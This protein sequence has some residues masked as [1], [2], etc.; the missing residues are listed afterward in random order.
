M[1]Y[2]LFKGDKTQE[3]LQGQ[4]TCDVTQVSSHHPILG[5]HCNLKGRVLFNFRLFLVN[6]VYCMQLPASMLDLAVTRLQKFAIFSKTE[7]LIDSAINLPLSINDD[8]LAGIPW[9]FPETSG[10]FTPHEL[11]LPKLNAVSFNK[12]CYTGQEIVARMH[13]RGKLKQHLHLIDLQTTKDP[14]PGAKLFLN[15]TNEEVGTIVNVV[16]SASPAHYKILAVI[17]DD[18]PCWVLGPNLHIN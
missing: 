12:G 3:F 1:S 7:L 14:K 17:K 16:P 4:L 6:A 15:D 8:V 5:A 10:L 13:Y 9:I 11:N 2:I 18:D